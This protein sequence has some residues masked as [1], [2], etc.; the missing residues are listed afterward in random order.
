MI[1][2]NGRRLP[3]ERDGEGEGEGEQ[4]RPWGDH[5][6]VFVRPAATGRDRRRRPRRDDRPHL[7]DIVT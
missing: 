7:F 1:L 5:L 2:P 6:P 3:L 4:R